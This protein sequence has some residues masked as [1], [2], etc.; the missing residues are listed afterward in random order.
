M[1]TEYLPIF[2][3][4]TISESTSTNMNTV[5]APPCIFHHVSTML[6][7]AALYSQSILDIDAYTCTKEEHHKQIGRC[8]A[9]LVDWLA[10][11]YD[12]ITMTGDYC[13]ER[14]RLVDAAWH[15]DKIFPR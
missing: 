5:P 7:Y 14:I 13:N 8:D 11:F 3:S 4:D 9:K 6:S 15:R 10:L 12:E 1:V 2:P